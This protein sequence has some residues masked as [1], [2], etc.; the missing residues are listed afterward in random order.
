MN[1]NKKMIYVYASNILEYDA[2]AATKEFSGQVKGV[3]IEDA[4]QR[5]KRNIKRDLGAPAISLHQMLQKYS[6]ERVL[7]ASSKAFS[8]V[9]KLEGFGIH[10]VEIY[11]SAVGKRTPLYPENV[12]IYNPYSGKDAHSSEDEWNAEQT[13]YKLDYY[14]AYTRYYAKEKT[15]FTAIEIETYNRCNGTCSFCP[16]SRSNDTREEHK[17]SDEL[18][19]KLIDE[20]GELNY[21]GRLSLFSNNEPFLDDRIIDFHK[22]AREHVPKARMHLYS[23]GTLLTLDKYLAIMPYLD[24]LVID[25]YNQELNLIP[26]AKKIAEYCESHPE[27]IKKTTIVLRKPQE[28]LTSRGGDAPNRENIVEY[29]DNTCLYPFLQMIIRPDGKCSLCCNDPLGKNTLGDANQQSLRDIWY[30]DTY[31]QVRQALLSGRKNWPH[32]VRCDNFYN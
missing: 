28:I 18:F 5:L 21:D 6:G 32:C 7:I 15:L 25:N 2:F 14:D 17:M 26:N 19:Y 16:V 20:L 8:E 12:L 4:V 31:T 30:G 10:S 27:F 9:R 3:V 13:A 29:S 22:Y 24:E 1:S 23:N 11:N